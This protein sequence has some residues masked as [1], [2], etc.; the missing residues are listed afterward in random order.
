MTDRR[1]FVEFGYA[2]VY[3][4]A[5]ARFGFGGRKTRYL[6]SLGRKIERLP[7]IREA[8]VN[9]KIGWCK[10]SRIASVAAPENEVM[11]LDSAL[12]LSVK[13][14]ERR[15]KDGTDTLASTL[16]L[17]LT[18]DLRILWENA[19]EIYRRRAGA[20]LSPVEAFEL[21]LAEVHAEWGH[22]GTDL[23]EDTEETEDSDTS[24][25]EPEPE[26]QPQPSEEKT[27]DA[28][29]FPW[30]EG[31][32][33]EQA[34]LWEDER[35]A[36]SAFAKNSDYNDVRHHV[37]ERDGWKCTY[38]GCGARAQLHVHH[39]RFRSRGGGDTAWNLTVVCAFHHRLIHTE[40]IGV[41][42]HAPVGLE[43]TPP[44]LMQ[45]VL[46]RRR[47]NPSIWTN[48]LEVREWSLE[49]RTLAT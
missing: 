46:D 30:V 5:Q 37:L 49:S 19:L 47:N 27:L 36:E 29:V 31:I 8:L 15:I 32:D 24:E 33:S 25:P 3:D 1:A 13:Q 17:P 6:V 28:P 20:E 2:S 43:W 4:Y 10:A 38:P 21:M 48:E 45:A 40:R 9:G 35:A 12:S 39:I 42:G 16:H 23:S 18:E 34:T 14:L 26:P 7:K 22:Y 11:W 44:K 41:Q